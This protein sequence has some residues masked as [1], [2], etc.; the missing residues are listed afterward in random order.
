MCVSRW[1]G[2][3]FLIF[4]VLGTKVLRFLLCFMVA[5]NYRRQPWLFT[6]HGLN[7]TIIKYLATYSMEFP[8]FRQ[9]R[10][11]MCMLICTQIYRS[12]PHR[13]LM[14]I[15]FFACFLAVQMEVLMFPYLFSQKKFL[16]CFGHVSGAYVDNK[17][18]M[19]VSEFEASDLWDTYFYKSSK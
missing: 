18:S 10:C 5:Q 9:S 2:L 14:L 6:R 11:S 13:Y 1:L 4:L 8:V 3:M 7:K 17:A 12:G 19:H 16:N 15:I